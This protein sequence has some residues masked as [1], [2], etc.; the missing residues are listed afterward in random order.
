[1]PI[2]EYECASCHY[3]FEERQGFDADPVAICPR[4]RNQAFRI[5]H[6]APVIYKGSGF[7]TTD[8][9]RGSSSNSRSRDKESEREKESKSA[10]KE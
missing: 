4:C 8:Y 1:V 6:A 7:Y 10:E 3:R 5:I 9:G 2:Y